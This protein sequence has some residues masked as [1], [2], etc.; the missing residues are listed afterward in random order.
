MMHNTDLTINNKDT[1]C[2]RCVEFLVR[3]MEKY[4]DMIL[5]A[6]VEDVRERFPVHQCQ[7]SA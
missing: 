4:G 5:P 7:K 3:M 2:E 1:T 6:S